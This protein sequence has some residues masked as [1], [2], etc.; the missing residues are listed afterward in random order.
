SWPDAPSPQQTM[1]VSSRTAHACRPPAL[2]DVA[3]PSPPTST[4][5]AESAVVPSPSC[6]L[7]FLPQHATVPT[8][9]TAQLKLEPASTSTRSLSGLYAG[10]SNLANPNAA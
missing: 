1:L 2:T 6:P 7:S 8:S 10:S 5:L 3:S 9:R 4:G